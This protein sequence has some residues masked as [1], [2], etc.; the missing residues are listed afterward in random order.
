[1]EEKGCS[2]EEVVSL[3]AGYRALDLHHDHILSSMCT[4][5]HPIA[6]AVHEMFASSNLGDPGLFPGT[7]KVEELL[8]HSLGELMHNA[9]AGGYATS[10]GTESNLQAIRIAKKLKPVAKPN[11]V[12]PASAHFSFDK[13]CD[14]LGIE[15]RVV[16]YEE[17]RYTV[18]TDK[19][20]EAVDRNTIAV[21]AV[22]GTT[23]Y[24]VVD[25]VPAVAKIA[26]E[27]DIFCH[28]DAAF[29]GFVIPFL[30]N[31]AP[32]DFAVE[33]VSAVSLD[34]HK[35]GMSTIPCGCLLLRD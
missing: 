3:L 6:V 26:R 21:S 32:F 15:M 20:A 22:A 24:G 27:N 35:M 31:P 33:G 19:M 23:E 4:V 5:P 28:V 2:R 11:I 9:N 18:D 1:M 25:D 8:V 7:T 10:G 30:K 16:P 34:P 17:G 29:G 13:T 12:V 14:I